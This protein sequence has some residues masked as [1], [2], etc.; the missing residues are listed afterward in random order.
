MNEEP[1]QPNVNPSADVPPLASPT[2]NRK[3]LV[4][5][6]IVAAFV[7]VLAVS[8]LLIFITPTPSHKYLS[9]TQNKSTAVAWVKFTSKKHGISFVIPKSWAVIDNYGGNQDA[10]CNYAISIA[11]PELDNSGVILTISASSATFEV[12]QAELKQLY[13]N[14][15]NYSYTNTTWNG[16]FALHVIAK[17]TATNGIARS[18]GSYFVRVGS[19]TYS[20]P[21]YENPS[22]A[23]LSKKPSD[24]DWKRFT[25]SIQI[26]G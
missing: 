11:P 7:T 26:K 4:V 12:V 10:A 19:C 3:N 17:T 14:A 9:S 2:P 23:T 24:A 20:I 25:R 22:F 1:A 18:G 5:T 16:N 6:T 21:D 8:G 15:D 13:G